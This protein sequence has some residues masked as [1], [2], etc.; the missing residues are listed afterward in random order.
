MRHWSPCIA[1]STAE[2]FDVR[3]LCL[4]VDHR[5]QEFLPL[6]AR[7]LIAEYQAVVMTQSKAETPSI[8]EKIAIPKKIVSIKSST[9]RFFT[10]QKRWHTKT[11]HINET[12]T[13]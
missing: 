6:G 3:P 2:G 4:R 1:H 10:F 11:E 9:Y 12:Y 7:Y 8:T 5:Q 13:F